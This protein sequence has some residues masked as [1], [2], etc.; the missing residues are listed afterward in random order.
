M[1]DRPEQFDTWKRD[2]R[3]KFTGWD[4]SYIRH[5]MTEDKPP[6][7]YANR[8]RE[9][10][11]GA[12]SL[13]DMGTGGGERLLELKEYWPPKVTVT[14]AYPP[15]NKLVQARLTPLGV[16]V[17]D[18]D[19]STT[20]PMPFA[21]NE[22]DLVLNRHAAFN[23]Q[24][25][26]RILDAGGTFLTQQVH[27]RST[28]DLIRFFNS[29]P[30][31]PLATPDFYEPELNAAG[32][33]IKD[34]REWSGHIRFCDVGAVVYYLCATPWLVPGF[35][36]DSHLESLM[37][38]QTKLDAGELLNFETRRYLIEASKAHPTRTTSRHIY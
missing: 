30:A 8:A 1:S 31:W 7:S 28:E 26:A 10:M 9:L 19:L 16:A 35:S 37:A 2:E 33:A 17:F 29:E 15:N 27:G 34:I 23:P 3:A 20:G 36:V 22:F 14:E 24:H 32:M 21:S 6:W 13:L 4:F 18:T 12:T 38:L 5:R 25:V 11:Q